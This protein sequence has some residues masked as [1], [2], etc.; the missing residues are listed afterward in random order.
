MGVA[1]NKMALPTEM[2]KDMV[3]EWVSDAREYEQEL[4]GLGFYLHCRSLGLVNDE[5]D[6]RIIDEMKGYFM[7]ERAYTNIGYQLMNKYA[8]GGFRVISDR[9]PDT[10]DL[11]DWLSL[12]LSILEE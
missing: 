9:I 1:K 6:D 2:S 12:Y 5:I 10:T 8:Q 4:D 11:A 3:K 7:G